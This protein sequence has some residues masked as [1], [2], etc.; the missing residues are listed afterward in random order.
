MLKKLW[1][2]ILIALGRKSCYNSKSV[3]LKGI[4]LTGFDALKKKG[5]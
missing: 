5:E 3:N 2:K 4:S 1:Y